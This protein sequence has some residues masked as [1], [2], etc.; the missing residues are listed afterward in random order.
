MRKPVKNDVP[1]EPENMNERGRKIKRSGI[2]EMGSESFKRSKFPK[3]SRKRWRKRENFKE[4]G[5]IVRTDINKRD[6]DIN[7]FND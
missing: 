6:T 4:K 7:I 2:Y 5:K 3:R 1:R